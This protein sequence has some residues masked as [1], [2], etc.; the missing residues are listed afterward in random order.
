LNREKEMRDLVGDNY[1]PDPIVAYETE[2]ARRR[3]RVY[4]HFNPMA[5]CLVDHA[6][7]SEK[8]MKMYQETHPEDDTFQVVELED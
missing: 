8:S 2:Q 3:E 4:V 6:F 5:R 7:R 1:D